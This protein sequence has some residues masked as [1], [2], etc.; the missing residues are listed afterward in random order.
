[1]CLQRF[2]LFTAHPSIALQGEPG[3][4]ECLGTGAYRFVLFHTV[5]LYLVS[6][7]PLGLF[8]FA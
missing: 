7:L 8:L 6:A 3:I 2:L 5:Y 4:L 1:M